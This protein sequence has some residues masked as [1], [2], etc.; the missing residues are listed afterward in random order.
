MTTISTVGLDLAKSVFQVHAADARGNSLAKRRLRRG[1]VLAYFQKLPP[2]LVGMESCG[3]AHYWA[4]QIRALGHTVRLIPPQ[5]VKAFVKRGKTD[6][7]DAEAICEAVTR[8]SIKEV[9]VKTIEQQ[10]LLVLHRTRELLVGQRTQT[11]NAIRSHI[12]EFGL[13]AAT[14]NAGALALIAM[15]RNADDARLP[16][17]VRQALSVL[18]ASLETIESGIARIDAR[19]EAEH[20]TNPVSQRL[21]TIPGVGALTATAFAASVGDAPI[22]RMGCSSRG[23]RSRRGSG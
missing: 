16:A 21:D 20:K 11:M 5:Y 10:S 19:I 13:I 14:G 22:F 7:A 1:D 15:V 8:P 4:R 3:T 12:A 9:P 17:I 6:A 2:C 23:A 18:V